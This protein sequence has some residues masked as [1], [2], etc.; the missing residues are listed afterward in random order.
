MFKQQQLIIYLEQDY[1]FMQ[2]I[3]KK[4]TI[5]LLCNNATQFTPNINFR[6]RL[7]LNNIDL[8]NN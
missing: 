3:Y 8:Y 6:Y 1:F 2:K 7:I 5:L 4:T